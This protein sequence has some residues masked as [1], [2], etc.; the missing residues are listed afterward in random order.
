VITCSDSRVHTHALDRTP[1]GDLFMVRNI[2]NQLATSEGSV[3]YGVRHLR[4]PVLMVLGHSSCGAVK[5][6]MGGYDG[7]E[8]AI[9]KELDTLSVTGKDVKN[10]GEVMSS[11]AVNV[12]RQVEAALAKFDPEVKDGRLAVV[13]AVY[14]FRNDYKKGNGKLVVINLNGETDQAKIKQSGLFGGK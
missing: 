13:G 10:D 12:N 8:P 14:D 7:I 2:G 3:E 5:A 11:V 6:V 1:D 9:K 4:T